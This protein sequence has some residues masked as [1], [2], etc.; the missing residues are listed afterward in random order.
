M[1]KNILIIFLIFLINN[2][3]GQGSWGTDFDPPYFQEYD[4]EKFSLEDSTDIINQWQIGNPSKVN[5]NTAYSLP[6]SLIT[7]TINS[8]L[9]NDTSVIYIKHYRYEQP[10]HVFV[11]QFMYKLDGDSTDIGI[12][13]ISPDGGNNWINVLT[14]DVNYD[15]YWYDTKPTLTGSTIGWQSFSLDMMSWASGWGDY[16]INFTSD[17]VLFKF[18]YITDTILTEKDGWIIDNLYIDD[19]YEGINEIKDNDLI[20]IFPNPASNELN[21]LK[22]NYNN[23]SIIQIFDLSGRI[24]YENKDFSDNLVN[25]S[26]L[27]NGL[28]VFKYSELEKYCST[29]IK[30]PPYGL[31]V[32]SC[33]CLASLKIVQDCVLEFIML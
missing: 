1:K 18:T 29:L 25:I 30:N 20:S 22:K 7:D 12:I 17:I 32:V 2:S 5:F 15:M 4:S 10:F 31:R 14:E 28:Y 26:E 9:P 33:N 6:N 3:F 13:E 21:I 19:Y 8:L 11:L 23:K 27:D 24:I 16:P